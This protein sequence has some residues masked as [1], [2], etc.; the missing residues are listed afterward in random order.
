M[1][2]DMKS[3]QEYPINAGVPRGSVLGPTLF[4]LYISELPDNVFCN[5]AMYADDTTLDIRHLTCGNNYCWHLSVN[6]I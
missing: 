2:L 6:K 3:L 1:D 5:I 4:P